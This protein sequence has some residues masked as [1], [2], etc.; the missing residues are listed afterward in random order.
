MDDTERKT[1]NG[2]H[3]EEEGEEAGARA[4]Q[5]HVSVMVAVTQKLT[6]WRDVRGR[7]RWWWWRWEGG[8]Y[9]D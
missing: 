1:T 5:R 7:R 8:I 9:Q 2:V 3:E 6:G 4:E